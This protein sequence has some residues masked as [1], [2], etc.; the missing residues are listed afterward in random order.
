MR[1]LRLILV[2]AVLLVCTR[3][4]A[5]D[6]TVIVDA[7]HV[8]R[9][10]DARLFGINTAIWDSML[11]TPETIAALREIDVKTLRFPGGSLSDEYHWGT[12]TVN[13]GAMPSDFANFAHVATAIGAQVFI[14]VNYGSGT[15][16]EAAGWVRNSNVTHNYGFKYWE[17]G[18]ENYGGWEAD[19]N[20]P[21]HDPV[22]Y[23]RRA[24]EYFRQMKAQD[25]AIKTGVVVT[26][27]ANER[28]GALITD[29]RSLRSAA[30]PGW[31]TTMLAE[32]KRQGVTP[33]FVVCHH[34]PQVMPYLESD[35]G[36]LQSA[37]IWPDIAAKLRAQVDECF[38][39][40]GAK[41]ELECTENNSM[42]L[43]Y[44]KQTTSLVNGL[45]L[46]D[47]FGQIAQTEFNA[48][49]WWDLRNSPDPGHNNN[50]ALYGWR[51]YGDQGIMSGKDTR[52]PTFY[53][54]KL[55]KCFARPG[56]K[57]V[58]ASSDSELLSIYAASRADH[59]LSLLVINKSPDKIM[60]AAIELNNVHSPK[61]ASVFS[62]GIPQDDAARTG[63]ASADISQSE[64][65]EVTSPIHLRFTAYSATVIVFRAQ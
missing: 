43:N 19:E 44:G 31:N 46:A 8:I 12:G 48:F 15:P 45:Y 39:E 61:R 65:T 5:G 4:R 7:S 51:Q 37:G 62:Y 11:D 10:L 3:S 49:L 18:N 17:I 52:Y 1:R 23:A 50:A 63:N 24:K 64:L 16:E 54:L 2:F 40:A 60:S 38:G 30:G 58:R 32:L 14:T 42:P 41:I 55:I 27:S 53:A 34:Y 57:I 13:G 20:Q 29:L 47:S 21:P 28:I 6:V 33:D 36:L 25:P 56:D 9:T 59:S 35:T 22:T 26:G